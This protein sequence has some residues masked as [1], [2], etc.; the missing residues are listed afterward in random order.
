MRYLNISDV[1]L[2]IYGITQI[3]SERL[4][5]AYHRHPTNSQRNQTKLDFT[6]LE[7]RYER[8]ASY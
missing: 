5:H 3:D 2:E 4:I 8:H 6:N 1:I 7:K